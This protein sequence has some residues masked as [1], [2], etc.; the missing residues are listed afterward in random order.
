MAGINPWDDE[1]TRVAKR[2]A[3]AKGDL[4][5]VDDGSLVQQI[6]DMFSGARQAVSKGWEDLN[7]WFSDGATT[8]AQSVSNAWDSVT[9]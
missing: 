6:T 1:K 7:K 8:A 2:E 5:K 4:T 3:L 9:N